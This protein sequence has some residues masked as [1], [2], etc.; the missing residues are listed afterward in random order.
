MFKQW[1]PMRLLPVLINTEDNKWN[2][3]P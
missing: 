1:R 3:L 2:K